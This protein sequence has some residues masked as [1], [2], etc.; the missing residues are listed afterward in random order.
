MKVLRWFFILLVLA[1]LPVWWLIVA[2]WIATPRSYRGGLF[3]TGVVLL[4]FG[5]HIRAFWR[6][7]KMVKLLKLEERAGIAPPGSA[8]FATNQRF[9]YAM[10]L[11][12]SCVVLAIGVLA[13]ISVHDPKIV[14]NPNYTRLVLTY[15]VGS[16]LLTGFLTVR[17]L[18]VLNVVKKINLAQEDAAA[19][20]VVAD[21]Q[22]RPSRP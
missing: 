14:Y 15:F 3:Y 10:R 8:Y 2:D 19:L 1:L 20:T 5:F 4:T 11:L 16:I 18:W 6:F 17:D 12:E 13:I 7:R 22:N 21:A 9:R